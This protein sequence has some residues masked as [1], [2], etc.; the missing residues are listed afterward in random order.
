MLTKLISSPAEQSPVKDG[1]N[2]AV[3]FVI[4]ENVMLGLSANLSL[5]TKQQRRKT[6]LLEDFNQ[7]GVVF[8]INRRI[9]LLSDNKV[10]FQ[11]VFF[12]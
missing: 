3:D 9:P 8:K 11:F 10:F 12:H 1:L 6:F 2:K 5:F 7:T 4:V